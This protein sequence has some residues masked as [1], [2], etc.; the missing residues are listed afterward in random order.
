[1]P[2]LIDGH[3]LIGQLPDISL[4]DPNDEAKLVEK[5]RSFVA[6]TGKK[7]VVVFDHGLPGGKSRMSTS[8]VEVIFAARPGDADGIMIRRIDSAHDPGQWIVVTNDNSVL[9]AAVRRRM[10]ALRSRDFVP[11]LNAAPAPRN[12]PQARAEAADPRMSPQEVET[13]LAEFEAAKDKRKG[14]HR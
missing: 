2:Y 4:D 1:M 12:T 11:I 10:R 5:L 14:D 6:R 3:N 7:V 8:T 9:E 13:W